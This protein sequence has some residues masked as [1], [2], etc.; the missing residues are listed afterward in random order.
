MKRSAGAE[1]L[2]DFNRL[3]FEHAGKARKGSF[4]FNIEFID[5][6]PTNALKDEFA[7]PLILELM[8][9]DVTKALLLQNNYLFNFNSKYQLSIKNI[10]K[11]EDTSLEEINA[12]PTSLPV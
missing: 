3:D 5:G 4:K 11:R 1:Q 7:Q 10:G 12:E 8:G 9:D 6:K 2:L